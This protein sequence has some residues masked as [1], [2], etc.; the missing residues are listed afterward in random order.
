[1]DFSEYSSS[2]FNF[3]SIM[4]ITFDPDSWVWIYDDEECSLPAKVLEGFRPGE[5]GKVQTE[6][7][8]VW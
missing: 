6:D 4:S 1:M 7:G 5:T 8:E 3:L 2:Y